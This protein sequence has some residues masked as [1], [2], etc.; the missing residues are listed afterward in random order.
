[1]AAKTSM[2]LLE[3]EEWRVRVRLAAHRAKLHDR[4]AASPIAA[5]ISMRGLE[6]KWKGAAERLRRDRRHGP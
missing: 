5:E 6:R 4:S 1:M 3:G 2:S